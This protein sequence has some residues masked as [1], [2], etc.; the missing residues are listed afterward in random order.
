MAQSLPSGSQILAEETQKMVQSELIRGQ[1]RER[2][3]PPTPNHSRTCSPKTHMKHSC[4]DTA[5]GPLNAPSRLGRGG[6]GGLGSTGPILQL[7]S[8]CWAR[9]QPDPQRLPGGQRPGIS[10][11]GREAQGKLAEPLTVAP[12]QVGDALFP[13]EEGAQGGFQG[14][15]SG[16]ASGPGSERPAG[17]RRAMQLT[18]HR[19]P[20]GDGSLTFPG[21]TT[22]RS[23][24]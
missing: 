14:Q 1:E 9:F 19:H 18:E 23:C 5:E 10:P 22:P 7:A 15:R 17:R 20:S 6:F 16:Q 8:R 21:C 24:K 4:S 2:R 3:S 11:G 13:T 12:G